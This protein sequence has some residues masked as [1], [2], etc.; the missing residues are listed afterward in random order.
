M[1]SWIYFESEILCDGT[2]TN[3]SGQLNLRYK[4][5]YKYKNSKKIPDAE[6]QNPDPDTKYYGSE[7]KF[8]SENDPLTAPYL[9]HWGKPVRQLAI[10]IFRF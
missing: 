6:K 2:T 1:V 5:I 10:N 3:Q 7:K 9:R 8:G 4:N